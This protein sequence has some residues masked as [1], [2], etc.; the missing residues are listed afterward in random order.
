MSAMGEMLYAVLVASG[1]AAAGVQAMLPHMPRAELQ[2]YYDVQ[3]VEARRLGSGAVFDVQREVKAPLV[4][5]YTV[6]VLHITDKGAEQICIAQGGPFTYR[7]DAILPDPIT[8]A[9]WTGGKCVSLPPGRV[10]IETTWDA[11]VPDFDPISVTTEV[12]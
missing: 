6:R 9:W 8:L 2:D 12:Q 3:K 11:V 4:M 7:P 10:Q 1:L 5:G